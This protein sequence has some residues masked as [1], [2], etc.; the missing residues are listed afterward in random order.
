[1]PPPGSG[2]I[3]HFMLK[4][5]E[6]EE[7][8]HMEAERNNSLRFSWINIFVFWYKFHSALF[9]GVDNKPVIVK[10]CGTKPLP[11]PTVI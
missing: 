2:A 9:L 4:L 10:K 3:Y 7:E 8:Q 5:M 1:M 6:G 11:E